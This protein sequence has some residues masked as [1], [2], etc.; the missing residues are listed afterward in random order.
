MRIKCPYCGERE[1]AEFT[2]LGAA[3]LKRPDAG[4]P[5]AKAAFHD[6]V[7]MRENPAGPLAELWYHSA[8]C[9]SWLRIVRDTRTHEIASVALAK[10]S[11]SE[12]D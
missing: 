12:G 11:E 10:P 1:A 7:Y 6:Y 4:A 9:R 2:Y 8:G 3:D 5:G